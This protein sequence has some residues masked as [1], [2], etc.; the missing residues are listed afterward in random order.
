MYTELVFFMW[1]L[2]YTDFIWTQGCCVSKSLVSHRTSRTCV[3]IQEIFQFSFEFIDRS[4][5]T[6][7]AN[8][9]NLDHSPDN[10]ISKG[11]WIWT[12]SLVNLKLTFEHDTVLILMI[13]FFIVDKR[14]KPK[15]Y[16]NVNNFLCFFH[17]ILIYRCRVRK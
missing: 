6:K 17:S 14:R 15:P 11:V 3:S 9:S 5:T 7:N 12:I 2:C 13:P 10:T 1:K 16:L 8:F 4:D